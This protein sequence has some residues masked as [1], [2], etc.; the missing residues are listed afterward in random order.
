[1]VLDAFP[2]AAEGL[3]TEAE[4]RSQHQGPGGRREK[5]QEEDSLVGAE[6]EPFVRI[7]DKRKDRTGDID[8]EVL[9]FLEGKHLKR[10]LPGGGSGFGE[11]DGK[12]GHKIW[13]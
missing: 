10:T 8:L 1:M 5:I 2:H 12:F 13:A 9:V 4:V 7:G 6:G 3:G 11:D